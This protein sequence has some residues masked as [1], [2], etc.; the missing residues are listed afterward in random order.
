MNRTKPNL[1][2]S[3]FKEHNNHIA[4]TNSHTLL[5]PLPPQT[6]QDLEVA[7][8]GKGSSFGELALLRNVKRTATIQCVKKCHFAVM[9]KQGYDAVLQQVLQNN[10]DSTV[11]FLHSIHFLNI[12][13]YLP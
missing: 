1:R 8:L 13:I 9:S 6:V 12:R 5:P 3:T 2:V 7:R 10:I 4:D 11:S